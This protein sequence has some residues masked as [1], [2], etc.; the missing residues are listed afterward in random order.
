[1]DVPR[2]EPAPAPTA[3]QPTAEPRRLGKLLRGQLIA[4]AV[5]QLT[6]VAVLVPM[7]T[8][9]WLALTGFATWKTL[10]GQRWA[11][12]TLS[13]ILAIDGLSI[14]VLSAPLALM[15]LAL[16]GVGIALG[17]YLIALAGVL[18]FNPSVRAVF[19]PSAALESAGT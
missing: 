15:S 2:T 19:R 16:G 13:V 17:A 4:F 9:A 12:I 8:L 11:W 1:M 7:L 10:A 18:I 6:A 3:G 5:L 14:C